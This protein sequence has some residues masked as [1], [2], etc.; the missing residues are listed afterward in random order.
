MSMRAQLFALLHAAL[1][2]ENGLVLT[3]PV[4]SVNLATAESTDGA[5]A[6]YE[7]TP[8]HHWVVLTID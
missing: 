4:K 3:Y 1:H 6:F 8:K 7:V 5:F 2:A